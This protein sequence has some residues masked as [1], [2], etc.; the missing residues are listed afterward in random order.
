MYVVCLLVYV[1]LGALESLTANCSEILT[2]VYTRPV[3]FHSLPSGGDI[4]AD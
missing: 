1:S 2:W 4:N 3:K